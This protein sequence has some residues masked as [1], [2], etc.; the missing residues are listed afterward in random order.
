MPL[1]VIKRG[2]VAVTVTAPLADTAYRL[3]DLILTALS[4]TEATSY[5]PEACSTLL[6]ENDFANA[7]ALF[8]GDA[9][10]AITPTQRCGYRLV[11]GADRNYQTPNQ[12]IQLGSI[13]VRFPTT[14][15]QKINVEIMVP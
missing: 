12:T 10:V 7:D 9:Q 14:I 2:Y 4:L 15:N 6:I 3:Y 11:V 5:V 8:V 1:G 13:Y